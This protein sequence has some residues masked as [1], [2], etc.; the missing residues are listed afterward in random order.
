MKLINKY[1]KAFSNLGSTLIRR[2]VGFK[3]PILDQGEIDQLVLLHQTERIEFDKL[4]ALYI[5][6]TSVIMNIMQ[7][8]DSLAKTE[9]I[10]FFKQYDI[11][12][13]DAHPLVFA[14]YPEYLL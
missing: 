1:G 8:A 6:Q 2:L 7:E 11:F 5:I 10:I 4:I 14:D 9:I 3:N 13:M 12:L